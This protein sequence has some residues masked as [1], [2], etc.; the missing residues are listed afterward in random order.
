[1]T[2]ANFDVVFYT[3]AFL[4]PGFIWDSV[5]SVMVK[6]RA[7]AHE[8]S[9]L[10][11]LTLSCINYGLWIWLVVLV[12][13]SS[14]FLDH[15]VRS[16][17]AWGSMALVSPVILGVAVGAL[18]QRNAVRMLLERY[19][20]YTIH[21]VP[22]AWD[23]FFSRTGPVWILVTLADR[24]QVAGRFGSRSFAS[25][26]SSERDLYIESVYRV[27]EQGPW[28]EVAMNEGIW[29]QAAEIKHIEFWRF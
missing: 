5:M 17:A 16:A 21:P 22:T 25:S 20:I 13:K 29:I 1:M 3:F 9:L 15:P 14:L 28:T 26:D 2:F 8:V 23:Y 4:V 24:S 19:G 6:R 12:A 7:V 10:R 11:F 18:S 27:A